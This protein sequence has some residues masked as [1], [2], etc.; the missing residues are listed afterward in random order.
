MRIWAFISFDVVLTYLLNLN[1]QSSLEH[2]SSSSA[3]VVNH[4]C[5]P[6][7]L[8]LCLDT[9]SHIPGWPQT[10]Y[11]AKDGVEHLIHLPYARIVG[12]CH[13]SRFMRCL[14][15]NQDIMLLGK[16]SDVMAKLGC[17]LWHI[18][19]RDLPPLG[20]S[21]GMFVGYF[22]GWWL[23]DEDPA[24][25]GGAIP[26]Q[27]GFLRKVANWEPGV[28]SLNSVPQC[29]FTS[30]SASRLHTALSYCLDFPQWRT[31]ICL[32]KMK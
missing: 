32:C 14:W 2:Q 19:K 9:M 24:T 28:K 22:L 3:T 27:V 25:M 4:H 23:M 17:Q 16:Y 13:S 26:K 21:V 18:W 7:F 1:S 6:I 8:F 20:W 15:Q 30:F 5:W 10:S 29:V 12:M 31:V 11:I